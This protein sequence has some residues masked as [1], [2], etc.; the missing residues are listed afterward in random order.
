[1]MMPCLLP[2]YD[3]MSA[4]A[5]PPSVSALP[6]RQNL[7]RSARGGPYAVVPTTPDA[8]TRVVPVCACS[9]VAADTAPATSGSR[10]S[11]NFR[12]S[13]KQIIS[14]MKTLIQKFRRRRSTRGRPTGGTIPP[15]IS[16]VCKA[17]RPHVS[18]HLMYPQQSV[19]YQLVCSRA[20]QRVGSPKS[21]EPQPQCP[22]TCPR[23]QWRWHSP[24]PMLLHS[25]E[26]YP[27]SAINSSTGGM[28]AGASFGC[29]VRWSETAA[30]IATIQYSTI[31]VA[32]RLPDDGS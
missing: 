31:P 12:F 10:T 20:A 8:C 7:S 3:A 21:P 2:F 19:H 28:Q 16:S 14:K 4:A 1:M 24:R 29:R 17:C 13:F 23:P 11:C 6:N 30:T 15:C 25:A 26:W 27:V 32:I 9:P 5:A 22:P 18:H